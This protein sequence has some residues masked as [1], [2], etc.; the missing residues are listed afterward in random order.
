MATS[1][2]EIRCWA[3]SALTAARIG[4]AHGVQTSARPPPSPT[5]DQNPS[6]AESRSP[7][8]DGERPERPSEPLADGWDKERDADDGQQRDRQVAEQILGQ[9]ER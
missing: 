8:W 6:P 1:S 2:S 3:L 9:A 4:P 7:T 5:P